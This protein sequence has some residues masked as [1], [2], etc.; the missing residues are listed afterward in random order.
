MHS[1]VTTFRG[2]VIKVEVANFCA[3]MDTLIDQDV[4]CHECIPTSAFVFAAT[5]LIRCYN[6]TSVNGTKAICEFI[7]L[8]HPMDST[9]MCIG[10]VN[11]PDGGLLSLIT[12]AMAMG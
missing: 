8:K 2:A 4:F 10:L 1:I 11:A 6:Y 5:R 12:L 3:A 9:C 7:L